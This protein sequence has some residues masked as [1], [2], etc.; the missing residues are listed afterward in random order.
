MRAIAEHY[1]L[2]GKTSENPEFSGLLPYYY[3]WNP[4]MFN[5]YYCAY[6][7]IADTGKFFL[8]PYQMGKNIRYEVTT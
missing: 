3:A 5:N 4:G 2:K 8:I 1:H 6:E 7:P